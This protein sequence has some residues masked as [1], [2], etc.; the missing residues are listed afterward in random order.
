MAT[1]KL[2]GLAVGRADQGAIVIK[3]LFEF[4]REIEQ[5]F[6]KAIRKEIIKN[7]YN[8]AKLLEREVKAEAGSALSG[9]RAAQ[10]KSVAAG[11]RA[12]RDRLPMIKLRGSEPFQSRSRPNVGNPRGTTAARVSGRRTPVTKADVFFGAEFGGGARKTTR[13]FL[14]HR[15]RSGYFFWPTVRRMKDR[16]A[17]EYLD[18]IDR[19]VSS[20]GFK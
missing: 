1:P 12:S 6:G 15:G 18:G 5:E 4:L 2:Q 7:G 14:R 9:R 8:V 10:A 17:K 13:Q 3:D 20:F 19:V 16:I 11:L